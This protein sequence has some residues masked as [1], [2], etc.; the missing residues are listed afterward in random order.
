[1]GY[2]KTAFLGGGRLE[3]QNYSLYDTKC[4][5]K[6]IVG[7][8][9]PLS[10]LWVFC[11]IYLSFTTRI[12]LTSLPSSFRKYTPGPLSH[13]IR[14]PRYDVVQFKRFFARVQ[15]TK[16]RGQRPV[17]YDLWP[18]KYSLRTLKV[19]FPSQIPGITPIR[20][21]QPLSFSPK[22]KSKQRLCVFYGAKTKGND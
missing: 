14:S 6:W 7:E 12:G 22:N 3:G 10:H 8:S 4:E 2:I 16:P 17:L 9:I 11:R 13:T 19:D 5:L 15:G 1:M 18:L 20:H 21:H